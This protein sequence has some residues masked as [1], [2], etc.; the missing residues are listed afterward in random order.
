MKRIS[1]IILTVLLLAP[2][3]IEAQRSSGPSGIV[4]KGGNVIDPKN[5][6]NEIMDVAIRDG[7][8]AQVAKDITAK[9]GELVINARGMY[10]TPGLIDMHAHVFHGAGRGDPDPDGFTFRSGVTTIVDAGS[11]G[12][13]SFPDFK[14]QTIDR[15]NTRVL[16]FL[17]IGA[18]GYRG[19]NESDTS[20]MNSRLSAEFALKNKEYIVGFKVAHFSGPNLVIPVSRAIEAGRIAGIPLMLDGRLDEEILRLFRPGDIYTHMYGRPIVD[21]ASGKLQP[22]VVE[23]RNRGIIFDVGFGGSSFGFAQAIPAIKSGFY[24]NTMGTDLNYHSYNGAM[25]NILNVMSIFLTM[26]ME[27]PSVIKAVTWMPAQVIN[28]KELGHLTAGSVADVAVLSIRQGNFGYW[29]KD[30]Y[31]IQGNQRLECEL[32]I[33]EG[34]IVY[35]FN[36]ISIPNP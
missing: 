3:R 8:I 2:C 20:Q 29:D 19:K 26:G 12:W 34:K 14:K 28:H 22:F 35:D 18:E 30:N 16:A 25:K 15:A 32:T 6:I 21:L 4:I 7:K 9:P 27:L 23:A 17:N 36:G 10:V 24:P 33:R 5:D 13:K 11:S 1:L 31:K